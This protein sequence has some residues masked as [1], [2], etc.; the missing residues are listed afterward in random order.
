[1]LKKL[2]IIAFLL[3]IAWLVSSFDWEPAIISISL[4]SS[5][6]SF[7]YNYIDETLDKY[8]KWEC[9]SILNSS[10]DLIRREEIAF[11]E[12]MNI[13][14]IIMK[15]EKNIENT[16]N[17]KLMDI[18]RKKLKKDREKLIILIDLLRNKNIINL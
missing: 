3:S 6:Y 8:K 11:K 12:L 10:D 13:K 2:N 5:L 17:K 14:R 4:L 9:P 15:Q 1:M 18:H 7:Q 16:Y